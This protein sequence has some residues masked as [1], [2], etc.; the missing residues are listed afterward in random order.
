MFDG[1]HE[2]LNREISALASNNVKVKIIAPMERKYSIWIGGSVLAT[3]A[4]FQASWIQQSEYQEVGPSIV[5][6]KCF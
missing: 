5:H 6:R 2:R 3:L 1:L 4:T